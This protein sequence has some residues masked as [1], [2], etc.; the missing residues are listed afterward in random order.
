MNVIVALLSVTFS[1]SCRGAIVC[2]RFSF[3][4]SHRMHDVARWSLVTNVNTC[5][6]LVCRLVGVHC[7][8][9]CVASSAN[10]L[11]FLVY[12]NKLS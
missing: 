11:E 12:Q 9:L 6:L 2:A 5:L 8:F 3:C 4:F 10:K 1:L 7:N